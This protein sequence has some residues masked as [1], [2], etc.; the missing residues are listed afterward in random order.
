MIDHR[1]PRGD[2]PEGAGHLTQ[3]QIL[4]STVNLNG[5][6]QGAVGTPRFRRDKS[7]TSTTGIGDEMESRS[8]VAAHEQPDMLE[9]A[10]T[11]LRAGLPI[12]PVCSPKPG[13]DGCREHGRSCRHSAKTPLIKW[14]SFQTELPSE[15]DVRLW[16]GKWPQANIGLACGELAG[17][18]V[19]DADSPEAIRYCLE[20]GGLDEAPV[21]LTGKGTHFL[22]KHPGQ[23]VRNFASKFRPNVDFR[24]D[25][26]YI[27]LP[28]SVHA[29]GKQYAW[30]SGEMPDF[31]QLPEVPEWL[32]AALTKPE[33]TST[34]GGLAFEG[35]PLNIADYDEGIPEGRRNDAMFKLGS[36]LRGKGVDEAVARATLLY[37]AAKCSPPLPE[38]EVL[39]ILAN[40]W[41]R[42][43]APRIISGKK[44]GLEEAFHGSYESSLADYEGD[45]DDVDEY[46]VHNL[47][48]RLVEDK[49]VDMAQYEAP[50]KPISG[51]DCGSED[52]GG[53]APGSDGAPMPFPV[54]A[55]P[56][57]VARYVR[58]AAA[59]IVTPP[60]YIA[61]P[62]LASVG[63]TIGG[64]LEIAPKRG[65]TEG[66]NLFAACIGKPGSKKS[67]SLAAALLPFR[68]LTKR[69]AGEHKA[70]VG[71]WRV[72]D[73][74]WKKDKDTDSPKPQK[75]PYPHR[76]TADATVEA[77]VPMLAGAPGILLL[78]D[79][80]SAWVAG[81]DQY[82]SGKGADRD[83]YLSLWSRSSIKVDRRGHLD[84]PTV[85]ERPTLAVVGGIQ[86]DRLHL[87]ANSA[88][89]DG[90]LARLLL[91]WP[92][93]M[94]N[95]V[96]NED[97]AS[98]EATEAVC[99]LFELLDGLPYD[100]GDYD[101]QL[102]YEVRLSAE[103]KQRWLEWFAEHG[104]E[105][106]AVAD[107]LNGAWAKMPAQL[108]RLTLG[109]HA[110][111]TVRRVKP[112][113]GVVPAGGVRI[114]AEVDPRVSL[115]T[116]ESAI[117]LIE[118][119]KAHARRVYRLLGERRPEARGARDLPARPRD[120]RREKILR[121]LREEGRMT[122]SKIQREVLKRNVL[123]RELEELLAEM[124]ADGEIEQEVESV[125]GRTITSWKL[126]QWPTAEA[127]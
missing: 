20:Q 67:P 114:V 48:P 34:E 86:P 103:A 93:P 76:W 69:L 7:P 120:L 52:D 92:D 122:Q 110:I 22:L 53:V 39:D 21:S 91:S 33:A 17:L 12:F 37:Y 77:L 94:P 46:G 106:D 80:L 28:G 73:A 85:V 57:V 83:H 112:P 75:P 23:N 10:L 79:E 56:E 16:W 11:Y 8:S 45:D 30:Q 13:S 116:L 42:Y 107:V 111:A 38:E 24:G 121:A 78:M 9:A 119:F 18:V 102:A 74:A 113:I 61:V 32:M 123:G 70:A 62:L 19:L 51:I 117:A 124:E 31:T 3:T 68:R 99:A 41:R 108:L 65:W 54:G 25:G 105:T 2:P 82:K 100:P 64:R 84:E 95:G 1:P 43:K 44:S 118:Y 29:S 49:A 6:A 127:A 125:G 66:A 104:A 5:G 71:Q 47:N 40:V 90:F 35:E 72:D 60:E 26:G 126:A 96:I 14:G 27:L 59:A 58:E 115:G 109:L 55:L 98:S 4:D 36:S 50:P 81:M 89:D 101:E 97:E 63:P 88:G 15:A 87:L